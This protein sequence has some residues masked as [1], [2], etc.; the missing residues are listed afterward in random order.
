MS[1][2]LR[3]THLVL[4]FWISGF[5]FFGLWPEVYWAEDSTTLDLCSFEANTVCKERWKNTLMKN[6]H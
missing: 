5:L 4:S 3:G 6:D 2:I 1:S